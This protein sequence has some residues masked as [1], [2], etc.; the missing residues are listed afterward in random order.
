MVKK[1]SAL[2]LLALIGVV[3]LAIA[4]S[5]H[6]GWLDYHRIALVAQRLRHQR[7]VLRLALEFLLVFGVGASF[8]LPITPF[9]LAGGAIFGL[10]LGIL[11]NW[12]GTMLGASGEYWLGR[13]LGKDAV[14]RFLWRHGALHSVERAERFLPMTRLQLIPVVPLNV[15]SFSAGASKMSFPLYLATVAVGMFPSTVIYTYFA[16]SLL[17]QAT[18]A[19]R[20]ALLHLAIASAL[21]VMLSFAPSLLKRL[22]HSRSG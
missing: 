9:N 2:K 18:G 5:R 15:L 14:R 11:L 1:R 20:G 16:D 7:N 13:L 10:W 3:A 21:L 8:G 17:G 6:F 4:L 12:I 19:R 22:G